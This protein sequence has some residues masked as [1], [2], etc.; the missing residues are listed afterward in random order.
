VE[1]LPALCESHLT[2]QQD[3]SSRPSSNCGQL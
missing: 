3:T 1:N 2:V